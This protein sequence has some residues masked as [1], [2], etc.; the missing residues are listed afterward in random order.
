MLRHLILTTAI[1]FLLT[2]RGLG[3]EAAVDTSPDRF[4]SSEIV[5]NAPVA[6]VWTA[7]TTSAGIKTF[8]APEAK[9]RLDHGGDYEI[10]FAPDAPEGQR[11]SEGTVILGYQLHRMLHVTWALPPY[12]HSV[13][14]DLTTVLIH[15]VPEDAGRTRVILRHYGWGRGDAWDEAFGYFSV[16]WD[17]VLDNLAHRFGRGPINWEAYFKEFEDTGTVSWW[18]ENRGR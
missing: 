9:I 7:W 18:R 5:V 11:G 14:G 6:E 8:F 3:Q 16:T 10:Y 2:G 13:R 17:R 12:M 15:F 1:L 4:V